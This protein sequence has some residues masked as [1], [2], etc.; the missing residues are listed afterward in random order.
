MEESTRRRFLQAAGATGLAGLTGTSGCIGY[1]EFVGRP[2]PDEA[3]GV[4][5]RE[6]YGNP[7]DAD[8]SPYDAVEARVEDLEVFGDQ[9]RASNDDGDLI[10]VITVG[11]AEPR[12]AGVRTFAHGDLELW[13]DGYDY[14][15]ED[16]RE[17]R[18][19]SPVGD[20]AIGSVETDG[21]T[22]ITDLVYSDGIDDSTVFRL[23]GPVRIMAEGPDRNSLNYVLEVDAAEPGA[24]VP[25]S[26][27]PDA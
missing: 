26:W 5:A 13:G 17:H 14:R 2:D 19:G 7:R 16:V 6:D 12:G 20:A 24:A 8:F 18:V 11:T 4:L 23:R 9:Y 21:D 15:K 22:P 10:D 27:Y 1:A 25:A 3:S